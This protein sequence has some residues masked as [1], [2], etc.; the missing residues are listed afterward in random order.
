M[1][2]HWRGLGARI[3]LILYMH[4]ALKGFKITYTH[5]TLQCKRIWKRIL[6]NNLKGKRILKRIDIWLCVTESLCCTPET[7]TLLI[8]SVQSLSR[9]R[10]PMDHSMPGFPV[11][12]QLPEFTQ[13]HVHRVGDASQP[14]H[15]LSSPSPPA[16]N[17]SQYQGLFKWVSSLHWVAKALK[18]QLQ[19]QSFQWTL[20]I[21]L[22]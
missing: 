6:C 9:V 5:K 2:R 13:T 8:S 17:L 4:P 22:L 11:Y 15:S 7:N 14:S 3:K 18:F 19:H 10:D 20:S 16:L 1:L 12:D 21:D